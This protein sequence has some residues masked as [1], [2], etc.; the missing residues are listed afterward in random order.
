[1]LNRLEATISVEFKNSPQALHKSEPYIFATCFA[2]LDSTPGARQALHFHYIVWLLQ[3]WAQEFICR[4][5]E[6][7]HF[8]LHFFFCKAGLRDFM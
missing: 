6:S 8:R 3:G 2:R 5:S 7:L 4:V 1:M